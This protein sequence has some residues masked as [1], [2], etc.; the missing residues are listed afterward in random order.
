MLAG[1]CCGDV[2]RG[3]PLSGTESDLTPSVRTRFIT[4]L[5]SGLGFLRWKQR[6][7]EVK[8]QRCARQ[9]KNED[10]VCWNIMVTCAEW[11]WTLPKNVTTSTTPDKVQNK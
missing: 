3:R 8:Q 10:A 7:S 9:K 11:F 5:G 1:I 2:S 4:L 6:D